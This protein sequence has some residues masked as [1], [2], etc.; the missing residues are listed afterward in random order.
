MHDHPA[1]TT[2]CA[3]AERVVLLF[4]FDDAVLEKPIASPNKVAFLLDAVNDLTATIR[5]LGGLLVNSS[6]AT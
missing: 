3:E 1:L 6:A 5:D 2:A 4:V